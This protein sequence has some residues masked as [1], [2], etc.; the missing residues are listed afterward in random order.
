MN[1]RLAGTIIRYLSFSEEIGDSRDSLS[2][3]SWR[4]WEGTF[5]WLD[6]ANL[7]L[8]LL[9]KLRGTHDDQKLPSAVL[10]RLEQN[11][12]KNRLRVDEMAS[13]FAEINESFRRF[14]VNYAVVKGFSLIPGFCP[15]AYSRQQ[16]DLDYLIDERSL[17]AAQQALRDLGFF[18]KK[19]TPAAEWVFWKAPI[20]HSFDSSEQY[21]GNGRYVV[22]LLLTIWRRD[23]HDIDIA[24]TEF[25]PSRTVDHEW[26][27][28]QFRSLHDEEAFLLQVLH[29]FQHLLS[30]DVRMSWFYEIAYCLNRRANDTSFWQR[31]ERRTEADARLTHLVAIIGGLA[32]VFFQAPIPATIRTWKATLP[33]S[34]TVWLKNYSWRVV[35]EKI[36][37]YELG[38]FPNSK[39][40]LLLHRQFLPDVKRRRDLT[41][42]R[43]LPWSRI[44]SKVRPA[45]DQSNASLDSQPR[46]QL[47][48]LHRAVFHAGAGLRYL[49]EIPRWLWLNR[50]KALPEV[51]ENLTRSTRKG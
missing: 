28:I 19:C 6:N 51:E 23:A 44:E 8:Y 39:L 3:F 45:G 7:A 31:V 48:V 11:Y 22:E 5:R 2:D 35:F 43:L 30:G 29:T 9:R 32:D 21:E 42:R 4:Q 14:G 41:R 1:R 38:I 25:S 10:S 12:S 18:L 40:P 17:P 34:V 47:S 36:P 27:R 46:R 20:S 37:A 50:S 26:R 24:G 13:A 49:C 16:S 15:D 33:P